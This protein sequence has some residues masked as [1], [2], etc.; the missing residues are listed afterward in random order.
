MSSLITNPAT[1]TAI[2]TST[3]RAQTLAEA[4]V[5]AYIH[6][7]TPSWRARASVRH[8][9]SPAPRVVGRASVTARLRTGR[10]APRRGSALEL[11]P[12]SMSASD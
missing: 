2:P 12:R 3:Y 5:S 10:V 6:E 7:I 1:A 9:C 11:R 4:V 8:T